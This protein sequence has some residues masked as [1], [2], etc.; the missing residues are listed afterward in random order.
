MDTITFMGYADDAANDKTCCEEC[1]NIYKDTEFFSFYTETGADYTVS[2]CKCIK[3]KPGVLPLT[4][5]IGIT[6][7]KC[8]L[9]E[10]N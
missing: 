5:A 4:Q 10:Y 9:W 6:S 3:S 7:G 1:K 2:Y 8:G